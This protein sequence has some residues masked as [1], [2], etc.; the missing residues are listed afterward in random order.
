MKCEH[1]RRVL[2]V[3]PREWSEADRLQVEAHLLT[4]QACAAIA[5]DYTAQAAHLSALSRPSLSNAQQQ[6]ILNQAYTTAPQQ[7]H[8]TTAIGVAAGVLAIGLLVTLFVWMFSSRP[9]SSLT[10]GVTRAVIPTLTLTPSPAPPTPAPA[11]TVMLPGGAF[12]TATPVT[13]APFYATQYAAEQATMSASHAT[14]V[15]R[16][17]D[18]P[19]PTAGPIAIQPG[20]PASALAQRGSLS[21]ELRLP[22]DTYLAGERG[23]AEVVVNNNG[24]EPIFVRDIEVTMLDTQGDELEV[25]PWT[26][27]PMIG[28]LAAKGTGA[29]LPG[30]TFT[31]TLDFQMPPAAQTAN[32]AYTLWSALN[33][34]RTSPAYPDQPDDLWLRSETGPIPLNVVAPTTAQQLM[35]DLQIDRTGWHLRVTD[36]N[37]Q[38]PPGRLWGEFEAI[39]PNGAAKGPL[40]IGAA[41]TSSGEWGDARISQSEGFIAIRAWVAAPGYV[42]AAITRTLPADAPLSDINRRF[43]ATEPIARQTF[44]SLEAAQSAVG[45]PLYQLTRLPAGTILQNVMQVE[46]IPYEG[47]RRTNLTQIYRLPSGASLKLSQML[48]TEPADFSIWGPARYAPEAQ[49]VSIGETTGYLIHRFDQ[50]VLD[51]KLGAIGFELSVPVSAISSEELL[52]VAV[53]VHPPR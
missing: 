53:G 31:Q 12:A 17:T 19:F 48:T 49:L 15:A 39:W 40:Q 9:P 37:G 4:C 27:M 51:W 33:F 26:P 32:Q 21:I 41:G 46:T 52:N 43:G 45:F 18:V 28:G 34:S 42:T 3:S 23:R 14:A 1:V 44:T 11:P 20:Q 2:A 24:S 10:V 36:A 38:T 5:R 30:Q 25:W 6:A 7:R 13:P 35:A 47:Q 16:A 50:W 29:L 22:K 8:F